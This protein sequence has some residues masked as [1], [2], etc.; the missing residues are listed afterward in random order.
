MAEERSADN[1]SAEHLERFRRELVG[2]CYRMLGSPFDAEDAVQETLLRAWRAQSS[3]DASMASVRTWLYR[4]ATNICLDMV[5]TASRR[6]ELAV[7]MGPAWVP[8]P[9]L[10][11]PLPE[12]AW[13]LPIPDSLVIDGSGD[14]AEQ[15]V[16][17]DSIR[18]AFIA[19]LQRLPPRQRATLILKDVLAY[20]A[21]EIAGVL[22]TTAASVNSAL[23]RARTTLRTEG[24]E[25][26]ALDT[27]SDA[28][29]RRYYE[30]FERSDIEAL[31]ELLREDGTTSMPPY[32]WWLH[33]RA[34]MASALRAAGDPCA[35]SRLVPVRAAGT[36]AVAQYRPG[37]DGQLRPFALAVMEWRGGRL[38]AT[39][40]FLGRP[41]EMFRLFGLSDEFR[42]PASYTPA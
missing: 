4:I 27:N 15:A 12:T 37:G 3:F 36:T 22:D 35:G 34:A 13:V 38:M 10:G 33:G 2:Y 24:R 40:T 41:V 20:S 28:L 29:L 7:D 21:A 8:G 42:D 31:I 23:Q 25:P 6:R 5:G 30:A 32:R 39:T 11:A 19:A 1:L 18:L 9:D 14:P 17:R 16:L 26:G